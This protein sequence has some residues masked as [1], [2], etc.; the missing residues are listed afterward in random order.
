MTRTMK[1]SIIIAGKIE[2][3][4]ERERKIRAGTGKQTATDMAANEIGTAGM[5]MKRKRKKTIEGVV[6]A[7][8]ELQAVETMMTMTTIETREARTGTEN[9]QERQ[10]KAELRIGTETA[11]GT[12]IENATETESATGTESVSE[13]EIGRGKEKETE[14]ELRPRGDLIPCL[15]LLLWRI[16]LL[17]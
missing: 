11:I 1:I 13:I 3:V 16:Q 8:K 10:A 4:S 6:A 17:L 7:G 5:T 2:I 14:K 12:V 15:R 9:D